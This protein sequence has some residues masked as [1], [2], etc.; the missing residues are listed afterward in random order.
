MNGNEQR[1]GLC[2]HSEHCSGRLN[3]AWE[4]TPGIV[5]V[6]VCKLRSVPLSSHLWM[7]GPTHPNS[8]PGVL[9][10]K[11]KWWKLLSGGTWGEDQRVQHSSCR[12]VQGVDKKGILQLSQMESWSSERNQSGE[13]A[14]KKNKTKPSKV[15]KKKKDGE[16]SRK[17]RGIWLSERREKWIYLTI[18]GGLGNEN[19]D[20]SGFICVGLDGKVSAVLTMNFGLWD[21]SPQGWVGWVCRRAARCTALFSLYSRVQHCSC[22]GEGGNSFKGG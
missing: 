13:I 15:E 19:N 12:K 5:P 16:I 1:E 14:L 9:K 21:L 18:W 3:P 11:A 8:S 17:R 7:V 10:S 4:A 22:D 2:L 6:L 20:I